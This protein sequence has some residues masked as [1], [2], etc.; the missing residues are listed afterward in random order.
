MISRTA[1]D[2]VKKREMNYFKLLLDIRAVINTNKLSS[3]DKKIT[4]IDELLKDN[5]M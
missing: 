3:N 4:V 5:D 2:E 1:F